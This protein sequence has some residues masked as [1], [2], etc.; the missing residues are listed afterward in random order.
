MLTRCVLACAL[1]VPGMAEALDLATM[2]ANNR[3]IACV[4]YGLIDLDMRRLNGRVD[5]PTYQYERNQLIWKIQNKGDNYNYARDFRRL[6]TYANEILAS[7]PTPD[8]FAASVASCRAL[9]RL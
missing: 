5:E 7:Q 6:N 2:S 9:L 8:T 1:V 4:A 3:R